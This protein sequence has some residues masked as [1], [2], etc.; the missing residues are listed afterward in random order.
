MPITITWLDEQRILEYRLQGVVTRADLARA[1]IPFAFS[2]T[3][4]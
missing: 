4:D 3:G 1:L 2:A